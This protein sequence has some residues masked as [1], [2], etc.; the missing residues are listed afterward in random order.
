MISDCLVDHPGGSETTPSSG[1]V[2]FGQAGRQGR[3]QEGL[4]ECTTQP[5]I[6][7]THGQPGGLLPGSTPAGRVAKPGGRRGVASSDVQAP[8]RLPPLA[9]HGN[10]DA[11]RCEYSQLVARSHR[12]RHRKGRCHWRGSHS[13][14]GH[15]GTGW[16]IHA[17][18]G[19]TPVG[20][21]PGGQGR[22]GQASV[23]VQPSPWQRRASPSTCVAPSH[24]RWQAWLWHNVHRPHGSGSLSVQTPVWI[25]AQGTARPICPYVSRADGGNMGRD[26]IAWRVLLGRGEGRRRGGA[27]RRL[28]CSWSAGWS[29][30]L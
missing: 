24:R 29:P 19:P 14:S 28:C 4:P 9:A 27:G 25:G 20:P 7:R 2:G 8:T 10:P 1:P 13:R 6:P 22:E 11:A 18:E 12:H 3:G 21:L 15:R 5:A 30:G 23:P 17:A 16:A 26:R